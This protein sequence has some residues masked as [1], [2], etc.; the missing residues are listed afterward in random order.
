MFLFVFL[1]RYHSELDNAS[2][3]IPNIFFRIVQHYHEFF[4]ETLN[5]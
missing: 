2:F 1:K 5:Y 4:V 3:V